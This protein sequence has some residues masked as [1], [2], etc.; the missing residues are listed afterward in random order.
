MV[1]LSRRVS[2][3][4]ASRSYCIRLR[5]ASAMPASRKPGSTPRSN[6]LRASD[7]SIHDD[8]VTLQRRARALSKAATISETP[9]R[10]WN[11]ALD[12]VALHRSAEVL[13]VLVLGGTGWVY[14]G[15]LGALVYRLAQD[16]LATLSPAYWQFWMGLLLIAAVLIGR[17]RIAAVL[18]GRRA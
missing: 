1:W 9:V 17:E 11:H 10:R 4:P 18:R 8:I 6:R 15:L 7:G 14:G 12:A 2:T 16:G 13:I 3:I 5:V